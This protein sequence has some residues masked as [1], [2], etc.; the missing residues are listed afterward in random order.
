M[1]SVFSSIINSIKNGVTGVRDKVNSVSDKLIVGI[2]ISYGVYCIVMFILIITT[3][4]Y[5]VKVHNILKH[6]DGFAIRGQ[7][8]IDGQMLFGD[9]PEKVSTGSEEYDNPLYEAISSRWEPT[10]TK[11]NGYTVWK[12]RTFD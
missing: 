10:D 2:G 6:K 5:T 8:Y 7:S 4:V 1:S 9:V 12:Q 11:V 3:L